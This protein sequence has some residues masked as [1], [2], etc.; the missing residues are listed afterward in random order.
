MLSLLSLATLG[1]LAS[2]KVLTRRFDENAVKHSW[3]EVPKGWAHYQEAPKD[4]EFDMRISLKQHGYDDLINHL[5]EISNPSHERFGNHLSKEQIAELTAPHPDSLEVFHD[6]LSF[7]DIDAST[8]KT[9]STGGDTFTIRVSVAQAESMLDAKYAFYHHEASDDYVLRTMSYS[10]PKA[11]S[12][13][14]DLVTPTT[15]FGTTKAMAKGAITQDD[16]PA[17]ESDPFAPVAIDA[18]VPTSCNTVITPACLIGLYNLTGYVPQ[19]ADKN[20]LGVAGYLEEYANHADLATFATKFVS[21]KALNFS[22]IT[23]NGGKDDQS[24]P[25]ANLDIQYTVGLTY[26]TPNIYYST[27][28]SPPFNPDSQTPTNTNEPY[29]AF[30]LFLLNQTTIPQVLTTSYGDDE[31]TVPQDYAE[32]VCALFAQL[33]ALGTTVF[34]SSGD[35]GVGGGDCKTNDGTNKVL[36]Q[37]AFPASCP[38]VTAV[39]GT[40]KT[41]PETAVSFTGGGFSRYFATPDY[42][43]TVVDS[44][45][46]SLGT[47][48]NGLYNKTGRAYPDIAAQGSGFQVVIGG[49]TSSVGGTSA[50]SPT[51]AA[52]FSLLNDVRLASGKTSL[53]F[54]NPWLYSN[55]TSGLNDITSGS[56][57]G[58]ST[59]G[60]SAAKGWDPTTGLGTP[61]FAKLKTLVV[62]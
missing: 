52:V 28:G 16:I 43:K 10:L 33:G 2:A 62:A 58:C 37:P 14:V 48:Y 17:I 30:L 38:W 55:L 23:V 42:Q 24:D 36:F 47:K 40:S 39:G 19:A 4:H 50:S 1:A 9:E 20:K 29:E 59:S 53:G 61:D 56:N 15:Y 25:G 26:P 32:R 34:F 54:I 45:V 41:N 18:A 6:W 27:G 57:P 22:T 8:L 12:G 60:F 49:R 7:H 46:T 11:L 21:G 5:L 44:Y 13:H 35:F 51:V 31:Q 3:Y